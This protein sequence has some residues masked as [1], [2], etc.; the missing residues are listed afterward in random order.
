MPDF[1]NDL[2]FEK[3]K[4]L[5]Y[6]ASGITFT[7]TNRS[8]LE[9]RLR[10][11][12]RN[13]ATIKSIG[14]YFTLLQKDTEEMKAFLDS[15]TTNLTRFFR[16]M[17]HIDTFE[18]FVIPTLVKQKR[19]SGAAKTIKVWS[20]GC[21]TGEEPYTLAVVLQQLLPSDFSYQ[22]VASDISL[23]SLMMAKEGLYPENR[24][25]SVPPAYMKYFDKKDGSY[26]VRDE[27]M[28]NIKFD[29]HN[30]K[31]D[32]G[33]RNLDVVFCRNVLIYFDLPAQ[34]EVID[35]FWDSMGPRSFLFIGHS[36]SLFGME[37]KFE[38]LRTEWACIYKKDKKD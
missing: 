12:L 16:N 19:E 18:K 14:E 36:E 23:K 20:A 38:F 21:S 25:D 35:R 3:Y 10:E 15:V 26:K 13:N 34:K 37:T 33:Q 9:S 5:I 4:K 30:L 28:K 1:M 29:Y 2:D 31:F 11:R 24:M 22:V 6:D 27:I 32:S 7:S 17:A 8:I